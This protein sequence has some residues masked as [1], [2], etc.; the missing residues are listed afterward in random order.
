MAAALKLLGVIPMTIVLLAGPQPSESRDCSVEA[1]A[2]R[3]QECPPMQLTNLN[4]A[5]SDLMALC[6]SV[7]CS[8]LCHEEAVGDCLGKGIFTIT[9]FIVDRVGV[10]YVC[11]DPK[12][13]LSAARACSS[14]V[15]SWPCFSR[16]VE[17]LVGAFG[18]V[19]RTAQPNYNH[20]RNK[21]CSAAKK[22]KKCSMVTPLGPTW[23]CGAN[24]A[25]IFSTL[26]DTAFSLKPCNIQQTSPL[27][28]RYKG[29]IK[30]R[31]NSVMNQTDEATKADRNGDYESQR[32]M[33][34]EFL[35]TN[36][37]SSNTKGKTNADDMD[38]KTKSS[39]SE[40][41]AENRNDDDNRTGINKSAK[42]SVMTYG[43]ESSSATNSQPTFV[44]I[45][46]VLFFKMF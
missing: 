41:K 21:V 20:F 17:A 38:N 4:A 12:G 31:R 26:F 1:T 10:R 42:K 18:S 23:R 43:S 45:G 37:A 24:Q 34:S 15:T 29:P 22:F 30:C 7:D 16:V 36:T 32:R 8:L 19:V 9:D 11:E 25:K 39:Q 33:Y 46:C 27:F 14:H 3:K 44:V 40:R 2:I 13:Y 6:D 5:E 35:E 28:N